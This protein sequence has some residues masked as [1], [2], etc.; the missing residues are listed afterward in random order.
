M[1]IFE[2]SCIKMKIYRLITTIL[3]VNIWLATWTDLLLKSLSITLCVK[4]HLRHT[5][6]PVTNS[7]TSSYMAQQYWATCLVHHRVQRN[8]VSEYGKK[9]QRYHLNNESNST[10]S[11]LP[12][13]QHFI[14]ICKGLQVPFQTKYCFIEPCHQH[15]S[16]F[17]IILGYIRPIY[18]SIH[19][20]QAYATRLI[21]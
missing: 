12:N 13:L 15:D 10:S 1:Y 6:H 18:R 14:I 5:T 11:V 8:E 2:M 20:L 17:E 4:Q 19:K 3:H 16:V 9:F 21:Q 7:S